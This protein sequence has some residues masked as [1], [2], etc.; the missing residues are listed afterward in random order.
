MKKKFQKI[1]ESLGFVDKAKK[2]ELTQ[3]D[4]VKIA[5][6]Y[7][8]AH[9]ADF[10]EDMRTAETDAKTAKE[11]AE[12]AASHDAALAL[13]NENEVRVKQS[14]KRSKPSSTKTKNSKPKRNPMNRKTK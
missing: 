10:Y 1:L 13:L 9:G 5:E 4:W 11:N 14:K 6:A 8:T 2:N 7:K 12:K 3:E